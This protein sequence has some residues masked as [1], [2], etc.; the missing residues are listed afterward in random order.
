MLHVYNPV[1]EM[2]KTSL[3]IIQPFYNIINVIHTP[4]IYWRSGFL[5]ESAPTTGLPP[6][7]TSFELQAS[8]APPKLME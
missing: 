5:A 4:W 3:N 2:G 8:R 7:R 6:F 1:D